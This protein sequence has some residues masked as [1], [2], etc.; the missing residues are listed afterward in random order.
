[1]HFYGIALYSN[2]RGFAGVEHACIALC[3]A[4]CVMMRL[5]APVAITIVAK[6]ILE[7]F[8]FQRAHLM[9]T[10]V[11]V[12]PTVSVALWFLLPCLHSAKIDLASMDSM[13]ARV[14]SSYSPEPQR[15]N[16]SPS[17]A[18]NTMINP[19]CGAAGI[20]AWYIFVSSQTLIKHP[21]TPENHV[22]PSVS[23]V[24]TEGVGSRSPVATASH[25]CGISKG[26]MIKLT[27]MEVKNDM[28]TIAVN[29]DEHGL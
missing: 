15:N 28:R 8:E 9:R 21:W 23:E 27:V 11:Q 19:P 20:M 13:S 3:L 17:T 14:S 7:R 26:L 6:S 18:P 29:Q 2:H 4:A 10:S 16:R 22:T 12:A 1:M 24:C 25:A 5:K